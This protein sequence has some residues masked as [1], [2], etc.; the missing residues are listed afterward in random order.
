M[1]TTSRP[2]SPK[3]RTGSHHRPPGRPLAVIFA[4]SA[5]NGVVADALDRDVA[6]AEACMSRV[7]QRVESST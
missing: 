2:S 3:P 5:H 6:S 4:L 1:G 7:T